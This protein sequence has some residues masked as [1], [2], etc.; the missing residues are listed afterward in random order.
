MIEKPEK[1]ETIQENTAAN[2]AAEK[3][4]DQRSNRIVALSCASFF[5][6]MIGVAYA[7][8][9]L[10]QMFC[11]VTGYGGTTQ[12][13]EQMSD[14][15]LD[16]TVKVRFDA[17][18]SGGLP[19]DFK[20]VQRE[21]TVRIGETTI[22]NYEAKNLSDRPTAGRA[23]FNVSPDLTGSYF[24]KVQCFCF[25]DTTL[26]AGETMEMPVMFFVDPDIVKEKDLKGL[27]TITL[28]YTFFPLDKEPANA[29]IKPVDVQKKAEL[30]SPL[31]P[32]G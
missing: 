19:W 6:A 29:A 30:V 20:P 15:I 1:T 10:Y 18:V 4:R 2:S 14:T 11:Q 25:T 22:I 31:K 7:A 16:Q 9:P 12:R 21:V 23:T 13:V 5:V 8:V 3:A 32:Q 17:N 26:A 27:K 28:S 24:N